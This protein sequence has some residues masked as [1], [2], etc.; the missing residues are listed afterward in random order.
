VPYASPPCDA[1][2]ACATCDPGG[3]HIPLDELRDPVGR[4]EWNVHLRDTKNDGR[5]L[6]EK[7]EERLARKERM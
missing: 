3:Y 7:I 5:L 2:A 4:V 1:I 6:I